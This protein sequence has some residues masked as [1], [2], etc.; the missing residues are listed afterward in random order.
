MEYRE[1][2]ETVLDVPQQI[3]TVI[4]IFS[5]VSIVSIA[6]MV[7]FKKKIMDFIMRI[8]FSIM[9]LIK[10]N[11]TSINMLI[12]LTFCSIVIIPTLIGLK[13]IKGR[14]I[15]LMI[16]PIVL[17]VMSLYILKDSI[18]QL[19]SSM[20]YIT[21]ITELLS[22]IGS[23]FTITTEFKNLLIFF[24]TF[25][26]MIIIPTL[27]GLKI[28]KGPMMYLG[29]IP[30]LLLLVS[31]YILKDSIFALYAS[32]MPAGTGTETGTNF[33][34][35]IDIADFIKTC[36]KSMG[37]LLLIIFFAVIFYYVQKDPVALTK[38]AY[39]YIFPIFIPLLLLFG[40]YIQQNTETSI[41]GLI[42]ACLV[43][44]VVVYIQT[45]MSKTAMTGVNMFLKYLLLPIICMIG[46]AIAYKPL[47]E[48]TYGLTGWSKFIMELIFYIPCL[49]LDFFEYLKE[50]YKITPNVVYILFVIE[51]LLI[52][53]YIYIPKLLKLKLK[54]KG[55]TLLNEPVF[56][57][58]EKIIGNSSI[59][60]LYNPNNIMNKNTY[61]TNYAISL[62]VHLNTQSTSNA[63]Y[64][65]ET[66]IF[67]YGS[68][69]PT[70]KN[71]VKPRI[72]YK[73]DNSGDKYIFYF[74][75]FDENDSNTKFELSLPTQKWN[76]IVL[77]Y[78]DT[79]ADLHVNG[80][81]ERTYTFDGNMPTY[82]SSDVF[83]VGSEQGL[84]GAICSVDY[85]A[86]PLK[87]TD[88]VNMYNMLVIKS[89]PVE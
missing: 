58:K 9:S 55:K 1:K 54:S 73:A 22:S 28:I 36:Y 47:S 61:K 64:A 24:L 60:S 50:Q 65:K 40:Y 33:S 85:F 39:K 31:L 21:D 46:L 59:T 42:V 4:I 2:I 81:L 13:I 3:E 49:I 79:R 70:G 43:A 29:I 76:H 80:K 77:N 69:D 26:S 18:A 32:F 74:T 16:I 34:P 72:A 15:F 78:Y 86:Y 23:I 68:I 6:L 8:M 7:V 38:N 62:W 11:V 82:S 45:T 67:E 5:I 84:D 57:N 37:M 87:E 12:F 27:I 51:I 20:S 52:L 71:N 83:K 25:C 53:L 14:L 66:T 30:I 17:F 35:N 63:A 56:L 75:K 19:L 41:V 10:N 88:I 44:L 48:Y 89:P